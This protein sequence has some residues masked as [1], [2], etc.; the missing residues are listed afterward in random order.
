MTD[1]MT[2]FRA[3]GISAGRKGKNTMRSSCLKLFALLLIAFMVSGAAFAQQPINL[4]DAAGTA[5]GAPSNYGT[6]PG[7][8]EV[9]GVNAFITNSPAVTGSGVFEVGPTTAANT[10]SNTFFSNLSD[11]TH[12]LSAA[13]SAWGTAPTGTYVMG[14][15]ADVLSLPALTAGSNT[16]GAVNIA[17]S[18][19]I[20]V[21]QS[22][23]A[24]LN[25]TVVG[26]GVFEVG[27][28]T[29]ANTASNTFFSNLSDGT[30][31]LSAAI[32]AWGTAPTG[33]Y[34]MGVNADVLSLP[35]LT[36]GSNTVGKVDLLGNAGAIMDA[37]GQN[38]ASPANELLVGAQFNTTPTTLTTGD[39]SPLQMDSTGHLL[40]NCTGCSAGSTVSLIPA[41]SGGLTMSHLIAAAST[42]GTSLKASAGELYG[43]AIYNNAAYPVYMKFYNLAAAPTVGT[44]TIVYEVPVQAGTEREVHSDEGLAFST[45]IAYA[46]TKGI[47]DTDATATAANDASMDL[48]YK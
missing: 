5:L 4:I 7:A 36:A 16:I 37:A 42:N 31:A 12:A 11:G 45:G 1:F 27:P 39:M 18:Q 44:S 41:T 10:A 47:A 28:T 15:N 9:V 25:A 34:V 17:A 3:P 40:V 6:S 32:S 35:A 24:S 46:L 23:A 48:I 43:A 38:A 13:I 2:D 20:A 26:S 22:S 14:V 29:G 33:T 8:V 19:T 30:H 21:T